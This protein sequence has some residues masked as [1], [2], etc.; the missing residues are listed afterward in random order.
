MKTRPPPW[1]P[2]VYLIGVAGQVI[3]IKQA[4][5]APY[6]ISK[7]EELLRLLLTHHDEQ[8]GAWEHHV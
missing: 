3:T 1:S 4:H 8:H 5:I 7:E 2:S 6:I